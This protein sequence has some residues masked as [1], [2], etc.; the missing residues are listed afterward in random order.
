VPSN[1]PITKTTYLLLSLIVV[2]QYQFETC[3]GYLSLTPVEK[4]RAHKKLPRTNIRIKYYKLSLA[5][6][7]ITL[8]H[9]SNNFCMMLLGYERK[10]CKATILVSVSSKRFSFATKR[11]VASLLVA[12]LGNLESFVHPG[13]GVKSFDQ[14]SRTVVT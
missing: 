9:K 1:K 13:T 5:T 12:N 14:Q 6:L 10:R 8:Q 11:R 4:A 2:L 7:P 3:A